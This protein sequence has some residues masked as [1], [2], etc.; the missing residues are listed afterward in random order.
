MRMKQ[1][2]IIILHGWNLS[3]SRFRALADIFRAGGYRVFTPDLP[4]FG[5][6]PMPKRPWHVVDYAEFMKRYV[7]KNKI[8]KPI[9]IGHSFGGRVALK[10][11]ELYPDGLSDLILTGTPGFSPV[12]KKKLFLFLL[13]AKVGGFVFAIPPLNLLEN[14]ARRWLYYAAGAREFIR[15]EGP[16]RETFKFIVQD[17]LVSAME[18]VR[19]PCLLLWGEYDVIVPTAIAQRMADVILGSTLKII[20]EVD[21]GVPFKEPTVFAQY[22]EHFLHH[23]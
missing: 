2:D 11:S 15:A 5:E 18:S 9:I 1:R 13:L 4:G 6:E 8:Y 16:M 12:P 7:D 14:W 10:Y 3:G 19:V 22:V 23:S 21:H 20:P 17:N